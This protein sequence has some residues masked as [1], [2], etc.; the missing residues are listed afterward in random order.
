MAQQLSVLGGLLALFLLFNFSLALPT[1]IDTNNVIKHSAVTRRDLSSLTLPQP[2][3][4]PLP[5]P[6][7]DLTLKLVAL[8]RGT[9]NYTCANSSATPTSV[10][11]LATLFNASALAA[12][13]LP[14]LDETVAASVY[15]P[16]PSH[17][18]TSFTLPPALTSA[19]AG[20][21]YFAADGT[22]T[23]DLGSFGFLRGMKIADSPA[24]A[25]APNSPNGAGAVDWLALTAKTGSF[26]V[27]EVYRVETAGG[28]A[29]ASCAG[30]GKAGVQVEYAAEY[31]FYG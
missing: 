10:G 26:G 14:L 7:A 1:G 6:A 17:P 28:K 23:F 21:H 30:V 29:P 18:C 11:A 15:F 27:S 5:S 16:D 24:P 3:T 4:T 12:A 25:N 31:W 9:Q 19:I 22:P 20:H 13:D 2:G 8:G